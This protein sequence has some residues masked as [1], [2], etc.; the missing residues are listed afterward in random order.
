MIILNKENI[1]SYLRE[2]AP[3]VILEDPVSVAM[4]GEGELGKD[5]EGDGYCNYVY[6][7][8]D[9][10]HSY[11]VKQSQEH[12]R[13]RGKP[14]DPS[15][16]EREYE[17][18]KLRSEIV[19]QYVPKLYGMDPDNHVFIMEDVSNLKLIRY[20]LSENHRFPDLARQG[21]HYLAATHFYTSE[22]YLSSADYRELISKYMNAEMRVIMENGIFLQIFG[23]DNYDPSC[24]PEFE[25]FCKKIRFDDHLLLQRYR[26]RH[27]F[28]SK[29]ETLIHGD[30]H[31][32]NIFADDTHLKVIDMEYTFGAPF[33][34]DLGFIIA[35]LIIQLCSAVFRPFES[36][37][38]RQRFVSYILSM[39]Q[40]FY[41]DYIR[42]FYQFWDK[43][44]KL[45]YR[46]TKGYK[47]TIA[48]DIL[49]ECFGF[50][51]CV[52]FSRAI[53]YMETEDFDCIEDN[54]LRTKAKF[55]SVD[56][57]RLLFEKWD[58]YN[59]ISQI[60]SDIIELISVHTSK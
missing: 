5:V 8:S 4:I 30:F 12:L 10:N 48:L 57:D 26:L 34:Y 17:I 31:T 60:I 27:L 3:S 11:I 46:I 16:N 9:G 28:M 15:R 14:M 19:P 41:T 13:R 24:G 52:N 55:L 20:Q 56:I 53:G 38:L 18:M 58:S 42:Y 47:E 35:N 49:R 54:D 44:A 6:R 45:E 2:Y 39:I 21:A 32:S 7:V 40:G 1:V 36:G 33:S 25:A 59:H 37:Y 43:D 29:S 51:A 22:F 23:S 50:A